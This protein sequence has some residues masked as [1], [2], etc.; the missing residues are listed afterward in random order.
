M[1]LFLKYQL[2][3]LIGKKGAKRGNI[4]SRFTC[5]KH[6]AQ[7]PGKFLSDYISIVHVEHSLSDTVNAAP[8][9]AALLR[10]DD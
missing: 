3:D 10:L 1:L 6:K 8:S 2:S 4:G 5:E 9:P 7:L